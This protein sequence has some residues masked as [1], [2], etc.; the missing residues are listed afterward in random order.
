M[1][2][3][4]DRPEPDVVLPEAR[5]PVREAVEALLD[6]FA[7]EPDPQPVFDAAGL[8]KLGVEG[9]DSWRR[10]YA[11]PNAA[12]VGPAPGLDGITVP[13]RSAV[14]LAR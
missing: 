5:E 10:L 9:G 4:E 7:T 14:L 12:D 1:S 2:R 6:E 11:T 3:R 13:P 8:R